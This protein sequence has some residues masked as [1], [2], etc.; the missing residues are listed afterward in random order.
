MK[1][2]K[3]EDIIHGHHYKIKTI[4]NKTKQLQ[5]VEKE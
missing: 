2:T 1:K 4:N 3:E 5:T